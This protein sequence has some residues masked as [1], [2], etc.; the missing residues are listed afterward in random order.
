MMSL[1]VLTRCLELLKNAPTITT[2]DIT[3]GA[4]ELHPL[5]R[6]FVAAAR[7]L[8]PDDLK[9]IDRC[10]LTVLYEPGQ[11]AELI[12]FLKD[13]RVDI[14][15]SLPCYSQANVDQQRGKGV[16]ERSI[17]A[18][19]ALNEA[20]Y[21]TS[22]Q[23]NQEDSNGVEASSIH[24]LDLVYNPSGAFLPPPQD[25][26]R[27][28]Y[29]ERLWNDFEIVFD[30]LFTITNMP[31][32]RF[33]DYLHRRQELVDYMR[34]LADNYNPDTLPNVMCRNTISVRYDGRLYDCDFNQQLDIPIRNANGTALTIF[35]IAHLD[36]LVP[37]SIRTAQHC[38]GCTAGKGSS[39]QGATV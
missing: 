21:G 15:A 7:S 1:E 32:Q 26:L 36:D 14:V 3:G 31:I 39:C 13:H 12:Q 9:I 17:A 22:S 33:A 6:Y 30:D 10:N 19:L 24:K 8:R 38:Y 34:L 29:K 4:P 2:L 16:F 18:L 37:Y 11:G 27:E 25:A 35:D 20:G 28:Q 5:F 23:D